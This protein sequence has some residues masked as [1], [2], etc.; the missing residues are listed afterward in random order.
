MAHA[1]DCQMSPLAV[2]TNKKH[3][4]FGGEWAAPRPR[5]AVEQPRSFEA[6]RGTERAAVTF[7]KEVDHSTL[8]F[9]AAPQVRVMSRVLGR[10]DAAAGRL[11]SHQARGQ[12]SLEGQ[13]ARFRWAYKDA[14]KKKLLA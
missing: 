6:A 12:N 5:G 2:K 1:R 4:L 7:A 9:T 14:T 8:P 10:L 11:T 13:K 3:W